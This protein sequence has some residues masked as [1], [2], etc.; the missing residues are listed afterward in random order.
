MFPN[1]E[2]S[3]DLPV[4]NEYVSVANNANHCLYC[5]NRQIHLKL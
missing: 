1:D 2:L 4:G 5:L 3:I